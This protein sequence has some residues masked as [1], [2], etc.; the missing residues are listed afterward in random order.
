MYHLMRNT[1]LILGLVFVLAIGVYMLSSV[2]LARRAWFT[3]SPTTT[4]ESLAVDPSQAKTPRELGLHL[5]QRHDL[6]GELFR[7][8]PPKGDQF[9]FV[10]RRLGTNYRVEYTRGAE[11]AL[12]K[13]NR[14]NFVGMMTSM[15]F[16]AGFWHG[17]GMLNLW[18]AIVLLTSTGLFLLGGT[19]VYLWFKTY[20]ERI[21]GSILLGVGLAVAFTLMILVRVQ[22]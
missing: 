21:I 14:A 4:E 16:A 8:Q 9:Q 13:M 7:V 12:V 5:M 15:H 1:H 11:E 20:D 18:G 2:R 19:G 6:V 22:G 3:N 10:I 17:N